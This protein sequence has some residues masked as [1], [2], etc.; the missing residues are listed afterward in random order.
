MNIKH[1][2]V[3]NRPGAIWQVRI[4]IPGHLQHLFH[5]RKQLKKSSGHTD[6][7][8][9][10]RVA[11]VYWAQCQNLFDDLQVNMGK[12]KKSDTISIGYVTTTDVFGGKHEFNFG[13]D[14]NPEAAQREQEAARA[15]QQAALE[16]LERHRDNPELIQALVSANSSKSQSDPS[17]PETVMTWEK[18]FDSYVAKERERV[19]DPTHKITQTSFDE[20]EPQRKL[21]E[22]YFAGRDVHTIKRAEIKEAESW[23]KNLPTAITRRKLTYKQ[24]IALAKRGSHK[25]PVISAATYNHYQRQIAGLMKYAYELGCHR[26]DLSSCIKQMNAKRGQQTFRAPFRAE[27]MQ[28][29]FCGSRYTENFGAD[30]AAAFA[31]KFWIPLLAAF[32]GARMDELCQLKISDVRYSET[33]ICHYLHLVGSDETAPDGKKKKIKNKN[34]IRPIPVH[35]ILIDIG[36]IRYVESQ[37]HANQEQ[38]LFGLKRA[39]D[40][41]YGSPISKWFTRKQNSSAL[42]FI[43]RCGIV[44]TGLRP[45]GKSWTKTFHS[46]RHTVITNLR[47]KSKRLPDGSRINAEDI[48]LVVGHL[49]EDSAKLET[50]NYGEAVENMGFRRDIISLIDYPGVNFNSIKWPN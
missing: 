45:D 16:T 27:D 26:E 25:L 32:S 43:E 39:P 49:E 18:L 35:P 40:G 36:F 46:F 47:D 17:L 29:M 11:A 2:L 38:S 3:R 33:A 24:A 19:A 1:F 50:H 7:R 41:K 5:G 4:Y 34:S 10:S 13:G 8:Q 12:K 20:Y 6:K 9:A 23:L 21:W 42:G 14:K 31:A 22:N 37:A 15:V 48:A 44:S 30:T 28:A